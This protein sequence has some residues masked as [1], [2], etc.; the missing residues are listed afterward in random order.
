MF[1]SEIAL[2]TKRFS[3]VLDSIVRR[4]VQSC[5]VAAQRGME[6]TSGGVAEASQQVRTSN[7]TKKWEGGES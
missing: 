6:G 1:C 3:F 2:V 5:Q 7:C 4:C